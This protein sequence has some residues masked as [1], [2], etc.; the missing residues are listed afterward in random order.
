MD[1]NVWYI[2]LAY[3][4]VVDGHSGRE[5]L[6]EDKNFAV[7]TQITV[8]LLGFGLEGSGTLIYEK[9][10]QQLLEKSCPSHTPHFLDSSAASQLDFV[11]DYKFKFFGPQ[12]IDNY[13]NGIANIIRSDPRKT[14]HEIEI[15]KELEQYLESLLEQQYPKEKREYTILLINANKDKIKQL[16]GTTDNIRYRLKYGNGVSGSSWISYNRFAVFDFSSESPCLGNSVT[17]DGFSCNITFND[18]LY[19]LSPQEIESKIAKVV[20]SSIKNVFFPDIQS[21]YIPHTNKMLIPIIV[22]R[23]HNLFNPLLE[24]TPESIDF[25]L[26]RKEVKKMFLSKQ[27]VTIVSG[28]HSLHEHRHISIAV[29]KSMRA[30]TTHSMNSQGNFEARYK[31]YLDTSILLYELKRVE[32][33]IGSGLLALS[34][35]HENIFFNPKL[36][37]FRQEESST[38]IAGSLGKEFISRSQGTHILP[39]YVFSLIG[40]PPGLLFDQHSQ[41]AA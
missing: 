35:S 12:D 39:V 8:A 2:L 40:K 32:D 9:R 22:L 19:N 1:V 24:G 11:F 41:Y 13:E 38:D 31:S 6:F 33:L 5:F 7:P 36:P 3:L 25:D 15:T 37:N 18:Q 29:E 10:L 21:E 14:I 16:A 17:Y 27:E 23:N 30:A 28:I 26:V 20:I 34:T 4:L